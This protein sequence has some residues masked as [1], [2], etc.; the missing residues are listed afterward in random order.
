MDMIVMAIVKNIKSKEIKKFKD[1]D[2]KT[3]L[4]ILKDLDPKGYSQ[5]E[6]RD[7][8]KAMAIE[9]SNQ[10]IGGFHVEKTIHEEYEE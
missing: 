8:L 10:Y 5:I 6:F 1:I 2:D 9:L 3:K 7:L 4:V